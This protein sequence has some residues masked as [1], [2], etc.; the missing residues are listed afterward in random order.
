MIDSK[1]YPK[2]SR[3]YEYLLRPLA[4]SAIRPVH[5]TLLGFAF[6]LAAAALV[7]QSLYCLA[8]LPMLLNRVL[9]GMDG[10][11]ARVQQ[12][13]TASG[14]FLDICLDFC[15]YSL[16]V[17]SFALADPDRALCAAFLLFSYILTCS[18]FLALSGALARA[19]KPEKFATYRHKGLYFVA[20]ICEGT[21]TILTML[22]M[23][24]FPAYFCR[25][26]LIFGS[27]CVLTATLRVYAGARQL[28]R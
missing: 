7:T 5:V 9:D 21:E 14:A 8:I 15:F 18:S 16:F 19:G 4:K 28:S 13:T 6:G 10:A 26:A 11:L 3:A 22:L 1:L 17:L 23:L 25:I 12:R 24:L 2:F 27:L 20:G